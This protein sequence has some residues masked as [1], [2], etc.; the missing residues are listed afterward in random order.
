MHEVVEKGVFKGIKLHEEGLDLYII[1]YADDAIYL[2][3]TFKKNTPNLLR[4]LTCFHAA[5][6]LKINLQKCKGFGVGVNSLEIAGMVQWLGYEGS[7]FPFEYLGMS[8]GD[9]CPVL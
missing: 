2:G 1:Q 9:A 3:D 5:S 7:C 4:I 8:V 6:G